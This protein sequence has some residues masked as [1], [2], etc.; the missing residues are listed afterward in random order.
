MPRFDIVPI[1]EAR[2]KTTTESASTR[3]RAQ[4]LQEYRG[5][6]DQPHEGTGGQACSKCW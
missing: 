2:A 6:M 1:E 3:K 4:L 5:Y